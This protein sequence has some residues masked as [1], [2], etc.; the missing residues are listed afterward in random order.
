MLTDE[1]A[2]HPH[3]VCRA[4]HDILPLST[5]P[6]GV[7]RL[8]GPSWREASIAHSGKIPLIIAINSVSPVCKVVSHRCPL[9]FIP[10]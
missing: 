8:G 10:A 1:R 3:L 4:S 9:S 2:E 5:Y 7:S 6:A